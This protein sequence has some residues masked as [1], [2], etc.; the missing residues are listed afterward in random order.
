[1]NNT[2]STTEV[3]HRFVC[4][5]KNQHTK[6]AGTS[7]YYLGATPLALA[8]LGLSF[9]VFAFA[10]WASPKYYF[11]GAPHSYLTPFLLGGA[12]GCL[13]TVVA[14]V[15][16]LHNPLAR[17]L[18]LVLVVKYLGTTCLALTL[19]VL[20]N[21]MLWFTQIGRHILAYTLVF[22]VLAP[23][24]LRLAVWHLSE[25]SRKRIV[26]FGAGRQGR[27]LAWLLKNARIPFD[28]VSFGETDPKLIGTTVEGVPVHDLRCPQHR[29]LREKGVHE[30]VA[31]GGGLDPIE[32]TQLTNCMLCGMQ[33]SDYGTFM[34]R[35][36]F[37]VAVEDL[38][39]DWFFQIANS[40]DYAIFRGVKR[41][42]DLMVAA[43]GLIVTAP[44]LAVLAVLIKLESPGP[45]FY[46]QVRVGHFNRPFRML[47]L[48]SM[49][50]DAEKNG[51]QWAKRNDARVTRIGRILRLTRMD[52][53]PQFVNVLRG[54]MSF[55]GPRPER[56]EFVQELSKTIPYFEHRHLMKPG[57]TGWAQIHYPYG[58]SVEDALNKLKYDLYYI[59]NASLLLDIQIVLRTAGA[60][61]KGAR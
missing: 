3:P 25:E 39:P 26:L 34:E 20:G 49:R 16:G 19:L 1:M 40:N 60:V 33:V 5:G 52:E 51:P 31:C 37:K 8:D 43:L 59:K 57:I 54:E 18:R 61:M 48:R 21:M 38:T 4:A 11:W 53:I 13:F 29:C 44:L 47:K 27:R 7:D 9:A 45:V 56:P 42:L 35:T 2:S 41:M 15:F 14:H 46:S 50:S 58:A 12:Y 36:F 23:S 24:L 10:C 28:V 55:V 22:S 17:R 6:H 32:E 30:I